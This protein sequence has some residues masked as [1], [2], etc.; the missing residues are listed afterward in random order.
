MNLRKD[1]YRWSGAAAPGRV[2][3][4]RGR[5]EPWLPAAQRPANPLVCGARWGGGAGPPPAGSRSELEPAKGRAP[6]RASAPRVPFAGRPP[7]EGGGGLKDPG[8]ARLGGAVIGAPG[9][10]R[11]VPPPPPKTL[12]SPAVAKNQRVQL[13]AVDHSARASMKNA[14][15][16]E[17]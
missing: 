4:C 11:V 16:C 12:L 9:G 1:H 6:C 5:R 14:A 7:P 8:P 15:S 17:K 3:L 2:N 13:L 10:P